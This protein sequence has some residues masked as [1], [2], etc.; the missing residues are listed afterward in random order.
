MQE[1]A[2]KWRDIYIGTK[3]DCVY[4]DERYLGFT[5]EAR[6]GQ[7]HLMLP[8]RFCYLVSS[9]TTVELLAQHLA[10]ILSQQFPDDEICVQ[11]FEGIGKGAIAVATRRK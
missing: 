3:E 7:F 10:G 4:E 9:D 8:K 11:A 6:Q 1:L 5:Y 2:G